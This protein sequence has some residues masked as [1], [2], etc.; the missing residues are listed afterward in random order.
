MFAS[1]EGEKFGTPEYAASVSSNPQSHRYYQR[2]CQFY[3]KVDES[4]YY[5]AIYQTWSESWQSTYK[6][7]SKRN[8]PKS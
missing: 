2:L 5:R 7:L 6:L 1:C 8:A 4:R 3:K